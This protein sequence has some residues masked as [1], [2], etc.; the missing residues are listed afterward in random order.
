MSLRVFFFHC[1][2]CVHRAWLNAYTHITMSNDIRDRTFSALKGYTDKELRDRL[3]S[4]RLFGTSV[5]VAEEI[6]AGRQELYEDEDLLGTAVMMTLPHFRIQYTD[7]Y[8]HLGIST[9][10]YELIQRA[11]ARGVKPKQ[12][13]D[14]PKPTKEQINR[15][16]QFE[17][18]KA[19][20]IRGSFTETTDL[21]NV[22]KPKPTKTRTA[23]N[24]PENVDPVDIREIVT[25]TL[26][27]ADKIRK[28]AQLGLKPNQITKIDGFKVYSSQ[29]YQALK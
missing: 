10:Y 17:A 21:Q 15:I 3:K 22:K 26:S 27:K 13:K 28:L 20:R 7:K 6:L 16:S 14:V 19:D 1:V 29:V 5:E 8:G 12:L 11:V 24:E 23:R 4:N 18:D 9:L 25:S 2:C